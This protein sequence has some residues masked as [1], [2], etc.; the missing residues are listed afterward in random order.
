MYYHLLAFSATYCDLLLLTTTSCTSLVLWDVFCLIQQQAVAKAGTTPAGTVHWATAAVVSSSSE[1]ETAVAPESVSVT[2]SS[3]PKV[4]TQAGGVLRFVPTVN[5]VNLPVPPAVDSAPRTN[6]LVPISSTEADPA[7][8]NQ[9]SGGPGGAGGASGGSRRDSV[10]DSM[11]PAACSSDEK[12]LNDAG[13]SEFLPCADFMGP[14]VS[15]PPCFSLS[16]SPLGNYSPL[17]LLTA[18][19]YEFN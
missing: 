7:W 1:A 4:E 16:D 3:T 6:S 11:T 8:N 14:G 18:T 10:D 5:R 12:L 19:N 13:V 17:L 2:T 9:E 15:P